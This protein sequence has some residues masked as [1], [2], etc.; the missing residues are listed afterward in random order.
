MNTHD[1]VCPNCSLTA[2]ESIAAC[3]AGC[4]QCWTLFGKA[5]DKGGASKGKTHIGRLCLRMKNASIKPASQNI[6]SI[7]DSIAGFDFS[8]N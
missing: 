7:K 3:L 6:S 5:L 1:I 2:T 8:L 4:P